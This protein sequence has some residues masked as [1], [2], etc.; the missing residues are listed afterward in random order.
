MTPEEAKELVDSSFTQI[1]IW[2]KATIH[3]KNTLFNYV[4]SLIWSKY[5]KAEMIAI[6]E[7]ATID[8]KLKDMEAYSDKLVVEYAKILKQ[9]MGR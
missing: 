8:E 7:S 6:A 2:S 1:H 3:H 5:W 4:S 9:E